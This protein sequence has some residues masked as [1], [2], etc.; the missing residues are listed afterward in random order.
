MRKGEELKAPYYANAAATRDYIITRDIIPNKH[1][2]KC[3]IFYY[4]DIK[5]ISIDY[6]D[7]KNMQ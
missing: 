2:L 3:I 5:Y 4:A 1:L 7:I 6:I